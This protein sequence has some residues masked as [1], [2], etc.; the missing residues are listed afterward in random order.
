MLKFSAESLGHIGVLMG[1]VSSEKAVSFKSGKAIVKAL[2]S[3]G[4]RVSAV[5]IDSTDEIRIISQIREQNIDLAFIALHGAFG[6]DGQL[7]AILE[8]NQ[9]PY[10]GSGVEASRTA[11]NKVAT[12]NIWRGHGITV[13]AFRVLSTVN[14]NGN[15]DFLA[16]E[17]GG[18]PLVVKP[19]AEGSSIG[20][21]LVNGPQQ[22]SGALKTA[23]EF[24]PDILIEKFIPGREM[25]AGILDGEA[26]PIV[27]IKPG[28][29]FF[30][31]AAKYQHG[32]SEYI[33][34]ARIEDKVAER[35]QSAALQAFHLVGS[36]DFARLD[37]ILDGSN[38][39]YFL[40]INTI[41]GFTA[42]SLLPMAAAAAGYNFEDL[43]LKIASLACARR[44]N[45]FRT[46]VG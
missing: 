1:G 8:K 28:S 20:V 23:G 12:Q 26:L 37:F 3:R 44:K 34:P 31:F 40:E 19:S 29:V 21:S 13:P 14:L 25:T 18:Y 30:D 27:E 43:C 45:S 35:V 9:I 41:P 15:L 17:L 24:G 46:A 7:Q 33:V 6:E 38:N 16:R 10:T 36:R 5:E 42:T 22:L 39:A 32:A 4:C 11:I 2:E